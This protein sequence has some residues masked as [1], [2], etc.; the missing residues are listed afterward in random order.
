MTPLLFPLACLLLQTPPAPAQPPATA[1]R[2]PAATPPAG[3]SS[4][5]DLDPAAIGPVRPLLVDRPALRVPATKHVAFDISK[6]GQP[7]MVVA[8]SA[9]PHAAFLTFL[10]GSIQLRTFDC[11]SGAISEPITS[12]ALSRPPTVFDEGPDG[13]SVILRAEPDTPILIYDMPAGT[14]RAMIEPDVAGRGDAFVIDDTTLAV[15][16]PSGTIRRFSLIDGSHKG[17]VQ[18]PEMSPFAGGQ[19]HV[20]G[21]TFKDPPSPPGAENRRTMVL[22]SVNAETGKESGRAQL[23]AG[24]C[25]ATPIGSAIAF[26]ETPA[27][28]KAIRTL[29]LVTLTERSRQEIAP[30]VSS[31]SLG[32]EL[33]A[34]GRTLYMTEYMTQAVIGWDTATGQP[35]ALFGPELGGCVHADIANRGTRMVAIVGPWAKG[36]L[37]ADAFEVFESLTPPAGSGASTER[38]TGG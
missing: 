32:I 2:P 10:N 8:L 33:S 23:P 25:A 17:T 26:A 6:I 37:V 29:E 11:T 21:I 22:A 15:A 5:K 28:W 12:V 7:G 13:A 9:T 16:S 14:L 24:P 30:N 18:G 27:G 4:W 3:I 1:P 19:G 20:I 31:H 35:T 36:A 38:D 34:D